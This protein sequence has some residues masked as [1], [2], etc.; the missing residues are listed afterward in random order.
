MNTSATADA[1]RSVGLARNVLVIFRYGPILPDEQNTSNTARGPRREP[2]EHTDAGLAVFKPSVSSIVG[3]RPGFRARDAIFELRRLSGLTWEELATLLSVTRR[4]LH[5]WANG[6]SINARNEKQVRDLVMAMRELD[7]GT[8]RENRGLLLAPLPD[9]EL[10]VGDLLRG[11]HFTEVLDLVGRGRGR[12]VPPAVRD[13]ASKP[14]KLS[15]ADMLGT[16]AAR[17]HTNEE[18][19]LLPRRGPRRGV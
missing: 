11:Q 7:R 14:E 9:G 15:V 19:A 17:I 2:Y 12:A 3:A 8:A 5:L 16:S 4:S 18:A 6:A 10:T 1:T 13:S